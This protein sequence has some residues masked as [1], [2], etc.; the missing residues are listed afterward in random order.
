[1]QP[2]SQKE[3]HNAQDVAMQSRCTPELQGT[4]DVVAAE[5]VVDVAQVLLL[6]RASL[7]T[8]QR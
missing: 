3:Q 2:A 6:E 4:H 1:M 7:E 5:E 8:W